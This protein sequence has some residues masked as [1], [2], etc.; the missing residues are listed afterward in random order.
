MI[1]FKYCVW[2]TLPHDH[3]WNSYTNNIVP[4]I[5]LYKYLTLSEAKDKIF[6]GVHFSP[7]HIILDG[8]LIQT[9][10]DNLYSLQYNVTC[11]NSTPKYWT[12][13]SHISFAYKY[14]EPFTDAEIETIKNKIKIKS[15]AI[16]KPAIYL[17]SGHYSTWQPV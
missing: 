4:H 2:Y 14:D 7:F 10:E 3:V 17:C 6:T 13:D 11:T 9:R 12:N 5:T 16:C 1:D 15:A 8:E